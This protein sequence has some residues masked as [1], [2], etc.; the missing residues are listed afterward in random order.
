MID[1]R[2]LRYFAT[3]AEFSNFT[4]A[5]EFLGVAQPALSRQVQQLEQEFGLEL[6]L[7]RGRQVTLTD[8]GKALLR[9]AHTIDRDFE[10]LIDDMSVRKGSPTGRV[11]I[12]VTPTL[13]ETLIPELARRVSDEFPKLSLKIAEAVTPVLVDWVQSNKVD[14]AVLSLSVMDFEESYPALSLELLTTEDM[15]VVEK[16]GG[17]RVPRYYTL[18]QLRKKRLVM[19]DMLEMVVKQKL[20]SANLDLDVFMEIDAVQA[21]RRMVA[22]GQAASILPVSVMSDEIRRGVVSGSGVTA[23]GVRRQIVLAHPRHRQMTRASEAISAVVRD[24]VDRTKHDGIYSLDRLV[25]ANVHRGGAKKPKL[26]ASKRR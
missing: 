22:N 26:R 20:G 17:I 21:I 19:S 5:A 1:V 23:N 6:F 7:R 4:R 18:E 25:A 8:A 16:A 2:K 13:A 24:E 11:V 12:G 14:L 15:I 10:Q 9:H 3:V